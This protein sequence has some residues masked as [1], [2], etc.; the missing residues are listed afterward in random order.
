M[1]IPENQLNNRAILGIVRLAGYLLKVADRFFKPYS[2]TSVQY[3][4]LVI[5]NSSL[6]KIS[7]SELGTQLVVSRSDITGI[8]DRLEKAGYVKREDSL[9]DRR[10][11]FISLTEKG[12][13]LIKSVEN[14]YFETLKQIVF[15]L[16]NKGKE[17]LIEITKKIGEGLSMI[18]KGEIK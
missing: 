7:Q 14:N 11:K 2:I 5:L 13:D 12:K 9:E 18:E 3:N 10:T 6:N 8:I 17:N 4:V 1:T 15:L 16:D